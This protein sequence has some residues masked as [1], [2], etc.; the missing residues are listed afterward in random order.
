MTAARYLPAQERL[1]SVLDELLAAYRCEDSARNHVT[2]DPSRLFSSRYLLTMAK[3]LSLPEITAL[4]TA[5]AVRER[6]LAGARTGALEQ[7]ALDLEEAARICAQAALSP[8]GECAGATFQFAAEA[9]LHYRARDYSCAVRSL[10][11][12]LE[13]ARV[14]EGRYGFDM[15]FR[16][17]HL[18][19]NI[20]RV[21]CVAGAAVAL[22]HAVALMTYISGDR[23][24]W[25]FRDHLKWLDVRALTEAERQWSFDEVLADV[26]M[27]LRS[28]PAG[29]ARLRPPPPNSPA[30]GRASVWCLLM[31]AAA[32]NDVIGMLTQAAEFFRD[33]VSGMPNAWQSA[34]REVLSVARLY[35]PEE[36]FRQL[37]LRLT[38]V[39]V[40]ENGALP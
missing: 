16:R 39:S 9:Y 22:D 30:S 14:L 25:P 26:E 20:V 10:E 31:R 34:L 15:A 2:V 32:E 7:A 38:A 5:E 17:A 4:L 40:L 3:D 18:G 23:H 29:A 27:L 36:E 13:A 19:R 1:R 28:T 6:G 37:R 33:G 11:A 35:L 21:E 24:S 8:Q 12:S